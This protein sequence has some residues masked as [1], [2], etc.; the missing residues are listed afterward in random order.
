MGAGWI[1]QVRFHRTRGHFFPLDGTFTP[2]AVRDNWSKITDWSDYTV[3]QN[4]QVDPLSV[5]EVFFISD[6]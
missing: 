5:G 4:P 6:I 2:E 3:P 1:S